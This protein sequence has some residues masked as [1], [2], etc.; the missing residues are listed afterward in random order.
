MTKSD[1]PLTCD[2]CGKGFMPSPSQAFDQWDMT[3]C[4]DCVVALWN[5]LLKQ[6]GGK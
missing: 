5:A 2:R 1:M 4:P 3:Y 6:A